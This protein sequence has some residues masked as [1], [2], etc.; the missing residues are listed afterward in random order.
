MTY[1]SKT[2]RGR[3]S[4][5]TV[6]FKQEHQTTNGEVATAAG[7]PQVVLREKTQLST[8]TSSNTSN[9]STTRRS[10]TMSGF[11][12]MFKKSATIDVEQSTS[13]RDVPKAKRRSTTN[14]VFYDTVEITKSVCEP[15][16][17]EL[18]HL[19]EKNMEELLTVLKEVGFHS[20]SYIGVIIAVIILMYCASLGV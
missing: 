20:N 4:A 10:M 15:A 9:T 12:S 11:K 14:S 8:S 18:L 5:L 13:E 19:E 3:K 2:D 6:G 16:E 17:F 1:K 7:Q